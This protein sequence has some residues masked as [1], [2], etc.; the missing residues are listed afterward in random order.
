LVSGVYIIDL[1]LVHR[2]F[3][4]GSVYLL[5][6]QSRHASLKN[7]QGYFGPGSMFNC[8]IE[9]QLF[10]VP[11]HE[12]RVRV[13]KGSQIRKGRIVRSN[14]ENLAIKIASKEFGGPH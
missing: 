10:Q 2:V 8:E 9:F 14:R 6:K 11:T 13:R 4:Q 1:C 5:S 12:F 7:R 3:P